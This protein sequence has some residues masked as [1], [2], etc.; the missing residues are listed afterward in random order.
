MLASLNESKIKHN[1]Q[2]E[3]YEN[4]IMQYKNEIYK[5]GTQTYMVHKHIWYTNIYGT[6]TYMVHKQ[7]WYTNK[8]GTQTNMVHKQIWY[9]NK[10]GTQT[11]IDIINDIF[12]INILNKFIEK[13]DLIDT[14][15]NK[16]KIEL[17]DNYLIY[18]KNIPR[19]LYKP[20]EEVKHNLEINI[21]DLIKK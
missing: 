18:G 15:N 4:K 17:P 7:I 10:Y 12:G 20:I 19:I 13:L 14:N 21:I 11:Y 8:Y 1:I 6:Q 2:Q 9:T 5:Y 16:L 3:E